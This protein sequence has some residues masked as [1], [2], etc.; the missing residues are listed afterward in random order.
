MTEKQRDLIKELAKFIALMVDEPK[1]FTYEY[2]ME[3]YIKELA[4]E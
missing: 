2:M 1:I 3:N 4:D